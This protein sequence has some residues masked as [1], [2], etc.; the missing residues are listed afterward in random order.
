MKQKFI[1]CLDDWEHRLIIRAVTEFRN[2]CIANGKP[3]ED[4][5]E[6]LLKVV[7]APTRKVR[8]R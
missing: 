7:H 1:V 8:I 6:L 5:N 4:L 3:I 2:R